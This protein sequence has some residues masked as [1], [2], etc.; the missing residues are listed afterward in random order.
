MQVKGIWVFFFPPL[1]ELFAKRKRQNGG[2]SG[3]D[4]WE[5]EWEGEGITT[6]HLA[7]CGEN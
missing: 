4:G 3:Q 6:S 1:L 5:E 2:K 7:D